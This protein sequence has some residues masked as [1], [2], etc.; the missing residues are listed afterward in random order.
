MPLI[1]QPGYGVV[2]PVGG[3]LV[4]SMGTVLFF[5]LQVLSVASLGGAHLLHDPLSPNTTEVSRALAVT[6][7]PWAAIELTDLALVGVYNGTSLFPQSG[8]THLI[9]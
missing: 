8:A 6:R 1:V 4:R 9:D 3:S 2:R 5:V 7:F